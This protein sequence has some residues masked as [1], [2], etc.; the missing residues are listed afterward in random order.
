MAKLSELIMLIIY[1]YISYRDYDTE[2]IGQKLYIFVSTLLGLLHF[3]L[4]VKKSRGNRIYLVQGIKNLAEVR[5][6]RKY[7]AEM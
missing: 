6:P 4:D 3:P 5:Y 7:R 1:I 2:I